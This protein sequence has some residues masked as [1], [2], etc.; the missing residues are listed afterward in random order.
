MIN[1]KEKTNLPNKKIEKTENTRGK[2]EV[3]DENKE[4]ANK[5]QKNFEDDY[6]LSLNSAL[7]GEGSSSH[8]WKR[9][10]V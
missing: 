5:E 2:G 8:V 4:D 6:A 7:I 1:Y 10:I 3:W 9:K